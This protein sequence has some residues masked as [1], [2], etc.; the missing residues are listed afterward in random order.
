MNDKSSTYQTSAIYNVYAGFLFE[1]L[2]MYQ[3]SKV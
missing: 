3:Q 1:L 2:N